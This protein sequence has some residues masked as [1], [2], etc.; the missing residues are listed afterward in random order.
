MGCDAITLGSRDFGAG[1]DNLLDLRSNAEF[2]FISANIKDEFGS[3]L[4]EP[5]TILQQDGMRLGIIGLTSV[6]MHDELKVEDPLPVLQSLISEVSIQSDFVVLLYHASDQDVAAI[7]NSSLD[8][9]LIIQSKSRQRS[10]NGGNARIPVFS[11]GDRGKLVYRF[12][13]AINNYGEK[14]VDVSNLEKDITTL[15][16]RLKMQADKSKAVGDLAMESEKKRI[17]EEKQLRERIT[18]IEQQIQETDNYIRFEKIELGKSVVD[19][20]EVL[21]IVEDGKREITK[22]SPQPAL[23]LNKPVK[24]KSIPRKP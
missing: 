6:V 8:I 24:Q 16:R 23:P 17:A 5:Y 3:L 21:I 22:N 19:E 18:K 1:L 9:D 12:E 20:P 14:L 15:T 13:V 4:F 11:C 7:K 10:N 2:H